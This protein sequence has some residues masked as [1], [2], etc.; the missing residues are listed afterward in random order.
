MSF[1]LLYVS[2]WDIYRCFSKYFKIISGDSLAQHNK[3]MKF[4]TK[5]KDKDE[6]KDNCV[7]ER[8]GAGGTN[9]V[10]TQI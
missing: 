2:L 9:V 1:N 7:N 10:S 6:W 5:D 8:K 4:L 3:G